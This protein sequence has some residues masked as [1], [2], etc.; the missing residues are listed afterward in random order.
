MQASTSTQTLK[1]EGPSLWSEILDSVKDSRGV[2]VK[3]AVVLGSSPPF[4]AGCSGCCRVSIHV[5]TLVS[6]SA[7]S[8]KSILVS[9]LD[10]SSSRQHGSRPVPSNPTTSTLDRDLGMVFST[11]DIEDEDEEVVARLGAYQI[12]DPDHARGLLKLALP[13]DK[14]QD[15]VV[16]VCLDWESPWTM[17]R[18]LLRWLRLLGDVLVKD[19][20]VGDS[21]EAERARHQR[22][23]FPCSCFY[24]FRL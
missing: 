10:P 24:V 17:I 8:G 14:L 5:L 3:N 23:F 19:R 20:T 16:V 18:Q 11:F 9:R 1:A 2:L 22:S 12:S 21:I 7:G 15:S 6:G 4:H 13:K